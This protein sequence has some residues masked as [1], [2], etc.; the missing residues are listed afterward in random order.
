MCSVDTNI[1]SLDEISK[2]LFFKISILHF[3]SELRRKDP[4][5]EAPGL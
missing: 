5:M 1:I 2:H 4:S 3:L